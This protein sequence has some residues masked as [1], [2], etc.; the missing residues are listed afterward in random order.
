[1][2]RDSKIMRKKT[3]SIYWIIILIFVQLA[4]YIDG[5][6]I[7]SVPRESNIALT[8]I[9]KPEVVAKDKK[10]VFVME[11]TPG[12]ICMGVIMYTDIIKDKWISDD[13]PELIADSEGLCEWEWKVPLNAEVGIAVF[14]G[15][16][17]QEGNH[18]Y[19]A[20]Q[21]FCIEKCPWATITPQRYE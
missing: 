18:G 14:R 1:M 19:I 21:T 20:P 3:V 4:C 16:V 15:A 17:L 9:R 7:R 2:S 12:N 6:P 8:L 11:T 10:A 5:A 13:L